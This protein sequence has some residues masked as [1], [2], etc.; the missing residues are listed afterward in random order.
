MDRAA[1]APL[2][3][4]A[5]TSVVLLAVR[6]YASA[7]VGF[8]DSEALYASYA[9][10]PTPAYVDH[11]G[12]VGAVARAI[13]GGTA[14][15][16][17]GA[18]L[19]TSILATGFPWLLAAACR[20]CGADARRSLLVALVA[21]LVPEIAVGLFALTPDLLLA[22]AWTGALGL[23]ALGLRSPAGRARASA[24][25]AAAGVLAGVAS[26]SKVTGLALF[27]ALAIAY[28]SAP[29]AAHRRTLA[30][31]AGLAAGAAVFEPVV[32]FEVRAGWPMLHH[33]LVDTQAA[34]GLSL[35]NLGAVV[36][37]QLVYLSPVVAVLAV[38]AIRAAWRAPRADAVGRLLTAAFVVPLAGLLPLCL[39]SRV[40]EPHWLAPPLLALAMAAARSTFAPSRR[41]YVASCAT[42]AFAVAAV[43]AWVLV[44]SAILLAPAS[45]D[46]HL[47]ISNELY[48]WPAVADAVRHEAAAETATSGPE[49][50]TLA[51]VGPH[52]VVCAQ[53]EA[54]LRGALPVGCDTPVPD[55]FDTWLPRRRWERD[56]LL[57]WVDDGRFADAPRPAAFVPLRART[58]DVRRAGRVVR[59]FTITVLARRAQA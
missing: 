21:A 58:V 7:H 34:A 49:P 1:R 9:L 28:A 20:A 29:A 32:A 19:V 38:L 51:V 47:D 23:A 22:C 17:A 6:L 31:W 24:A 56:D 10:H 14:P 13:G 8:G 27:A 53:L 16:P 26:A 11:P 12:L 50:P 18:H 48:G 55:D 36:A 46:A 45:S 3:A 57:L 54:A 37:G 39:W 52:W 5:A 33:R 44:P 25:F 42:A 4:L 2:V 59:T 41:L 43:H 15:S 35:R 40:A 30:P